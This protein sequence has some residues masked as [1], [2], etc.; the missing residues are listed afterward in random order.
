MTNE[1]L[2]TLLTRSSC[3]NFSGVAPTKEQLEAI[4][5]AGLFAANGM[6]R[7]S[8]VMVCVT[9]KKTRDLLSTLNAKVLGKGA[10][11]DPFY[12]APVVVAV[13]SDTN[14]NTHIEDGSLVLGNLMNAATSLG[15]GSCWIHRALQVFDS[16]EGKDLKKQWGLDDCYQGVGFCV[17]GEGTPQTKVQRRPGRIIRID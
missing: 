12:N 1:T 5:Q 7:Q 2:K 11:F 10:D 3:K 4:L 15:V 14:V 6:S 17:L 13:L 9:Q 16:K 8:A